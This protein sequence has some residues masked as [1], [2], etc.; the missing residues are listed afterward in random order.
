MKIIQRQSED[1]IK[2]LLSGERII[3]SVDPLAET[4]CLFLYYHTFLPRS[5]DQIKMCDASQ[6]DFLNYHNLGSIIEMIFLVLRLA[7]TT[8]IVGN[9][10]FTDFTL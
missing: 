9:S 8:A 10:P 2:T 3:K 5:K 7:G 1:I 4:I 6:M